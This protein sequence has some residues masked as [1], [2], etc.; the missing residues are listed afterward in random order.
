MGQVLR[1]MLHNV[2]VKIPPR[3][4]NRVEVNPSDSQVNASVQDFGNEASSRLTDRLMLARRFHLP[5]PSLIYHTFHLNQ[6]AGYSRDRDLNNTYH[7]GI[8]L[9]GF[10][11]SQLSSYAIMHFECR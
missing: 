11:N 3:G 1:N 8:F 10:G 5:H 9:P 7:D 2:V 6:P 4:H